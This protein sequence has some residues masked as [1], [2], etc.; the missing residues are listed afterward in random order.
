ME[1]T[2]LP[3]GDVATIKLLLVVKHGVDCFGDDPGPARLGLSL[4]GERALCRVIGHALAA[5]ERGEHL[6][7]IL[8]F[9]NTLSVIR[10]VLLA[11]LCATKVSRVGGHPETTRGSAP[12][13][14]QVGP[15]GGR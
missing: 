13:P 4:A 9:L 11:A 5:V 2:A 12:C 3:A 14:V 6:V 1:T 10:L 7:R 15:E 8:L